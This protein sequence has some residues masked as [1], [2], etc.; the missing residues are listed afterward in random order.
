MKTYLQHKG[1]QVLAHRGGAEESFENTIE[2]FDYS[3]SIGCKFIET[4]VQTSSDGVPYIFH[5]D[6]LSRILN[7]H[8]VFSELSSKEI[9]NL[10]IFENKKI[11]RLDETLIKFPNLSF[12]ID[13]KTDEVV[14]P[15]LDVINKLDVSDRVCIASFSSKRLELVRSINPNLCISMGPNEVFKTLIASWGLYKKSL[16]GDCLQVPISY[17]GIRLVSKRFVDF[18]HAKNLKI[19]VWTINDVKTF[20][21]LIGINVDGIITDRPKLLFDTLNN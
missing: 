16:I 7:K 19:M 20:K 5:D 9:D 1:L 3:R 14:K 10:H 12:Q 15:A 11:P 6:D 18:V 2:S 21:Y 8:I 4:D 13:F 17:Y